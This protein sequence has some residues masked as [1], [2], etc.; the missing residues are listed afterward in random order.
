MESPKP[1]WKQEVEKLKD[2]SDL[3]ADSFLD[4][5]RTSEWTGIIF[6]AVAAAVI[7]VIWLI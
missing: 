7:I 1:K 4:K 2:E 3:H 6:L 5:L